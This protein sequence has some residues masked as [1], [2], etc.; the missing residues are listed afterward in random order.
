[1]QH[2][3]YLAIASLFTKTDNMKWVSSV[4]GSQTAAKSH[5]PLACLIAQN[6]RDISYANN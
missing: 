6:T 4:G 5:P 3:V 2:Y 1:M